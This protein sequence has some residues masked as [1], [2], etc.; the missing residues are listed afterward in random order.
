MS[1]VACRALF[2]VRC[3]GCCLLCVAGVSLLLF[4]V[5][6]LLRVARCLLCVV[7]RSLLCACCLLCVEE[8]CTELCDV[9]LLFVV[10]LFDVC[11]VLHVVRCLLVIV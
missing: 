11:C 3:V 1:A 4:V 10:D 6:R 5:R 9:C 7:T 8:R 2:A